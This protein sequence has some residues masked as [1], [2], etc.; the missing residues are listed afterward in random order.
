[1][2]D[3][4]KLYLATFEFIS[5][6]YCQI[7]H[8]AFFAEDENALE[9]EIHNYL[10]DYYGVRNISEIQDGVYYYWHSE[11]AVKPI[12]WQEIENLEQMAGKLL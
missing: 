4:K 11:V 6:E 10:V 9:K 7:F 5:G 12:G 3:D 2:K 8:K 1:M